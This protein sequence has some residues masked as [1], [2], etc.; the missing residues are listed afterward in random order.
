MQT[1]NSV[2]TPSNG[3]ERGGEGG[4]SG[5]YGLI[6]GRDFPQ[7]FYHLL[8]PS[9]CVKSGV[10]NNFLIPENTVTQFKSCSGFAGDVCSRMEPTALAGRVL[11]FIKP[12]ITL[13]NHIPQSE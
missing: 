2:S 5:D 10:Y 7:I 3:R 6:R 9:P 13:C 12:I 11:N 8:T 4:E 1:I